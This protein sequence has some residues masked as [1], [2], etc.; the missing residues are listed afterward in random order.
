MTL[1]VPRHASVLA[2]RALRR[3][4]SLSID[5]L[6]IRHGLYYRFVHAWKCVNIANHHEQGEHCEHM[7]P[8][9]ELELCLCCRMPIVPMLLSPLLMLLMI[10]ILLVLLWLWIDQC[11]FRH[12]PD[13]IIKALKRNN[14]HAHI[15]RRGPLELFCSRYVS[16]VAS[17]SLRRC[18][19]I[20]ADRLIIRHGAKY[21][22][23][24]TPCTGRTWC[25]Y[26]AVLFL[27]MPLLSHADRFDAVDVS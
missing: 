5:R 18:R 17:R 14:N 10:V 19:C 2:C 8:F 1:I 15:E 27:A 13:Y 23:R 6:L 20:S 22:A 9:P 11:L 21:D 16:A 24:C 26:G 12:G 25:V 7:S 4:R 3:C